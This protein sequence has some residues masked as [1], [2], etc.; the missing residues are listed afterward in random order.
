[1][2]EAPASRRPAPSPWTQQKVPSF[3]PLLTPRNI[4]AVLFAT[5]AV[6]ITIGLSIRSVQAE[7]IFQQKVQYD[8]DGTPDRNSGCK[9]KSANAGAECTVTVKIE[10]KMASPVYVYYEIDNFYQNH[11]RYL[12]SL[13]SDQLTG[14]NLDKDDLSACSPLKSNGSHTLNPCGVIANSMFNDVIALDDTYPITMHEDHLAWDSDMTTKFK[15]PDG[16]EWTTTTDDVS[17]CYKSVCSELLCASNGL[18]A[19]CMGYVCEGGD[20]DGGHCDAGTG[21]VYYYRSHDEFQFLYQTFPEIVSP[22]VGVKNEHFIVWM[23]L[24]GLNDFRKLY[25]R[26]TDTLHEGWE[27]KFNVT[28]NFNVHSFNGK[29]YI[30]VSTVSTLGANVKA[31]WMSFVYFGVACCACALFFLAKSMASPR[32]LGD[33]A[34]LRN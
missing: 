14:S 22:I 34:Y 27:L 21:V 29:K 8:G 4:M 26:I 2:A 13:D 31:L 11:Q 18:P 6:F 32:K 20:Y 16:F 17:E 28:N 33:T 5:G 12:A 7:Q 24:A 23:R 30:V 10:D 3:Q 1:M 25:G 15:Q 19:G 9:I